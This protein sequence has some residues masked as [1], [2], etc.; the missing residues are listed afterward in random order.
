MPS[1]DKPNINVAHFS[2]DE[3]NGPIFTLMIVVIHPFPKQV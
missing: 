1:Q 3:T 2:I